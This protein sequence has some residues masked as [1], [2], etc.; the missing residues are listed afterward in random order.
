VVSLVSLHQWKEPEKTLKE[1]ER[2]RKNNSI[3]LI[4]DFRRDRSY[5]PFYLNS[6]KYRSN[7]GK[8]IMLN[9]RNAFKSSY[10]V[11]EVKNIVGK[12]PSNNWN[13]SKNDRWLELLS[14]SSDEI[15]NEQTENELNLGYKS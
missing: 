3:V 4:S 13:I 10:T 12:Q 2:V 6:R 8:E 11:N 7:F 9:L 1:I 15:H 5:L 14:R